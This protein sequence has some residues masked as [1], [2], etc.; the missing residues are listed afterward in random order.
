MKRIRVYYIIICSVFLCLAGCA[1]ISWFPSAG[2]SRSNIVNTKDEP[3][4]ESSIKVVSPSR[5]VAR[6]ILDNQRKDLFSN[7][8]NV[9][10]TSDLIASQGDVIQISIWE[11]PPTILF[12]NSTSSGQV[13]PSASVRVDLPQA[14]I[15]KSGTELKV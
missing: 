11:S 13:L 9:S 6:R 8:F 1:N 3:V 15:D 10:E 12:S 7:V 4:V 2:I 14:M 5:D